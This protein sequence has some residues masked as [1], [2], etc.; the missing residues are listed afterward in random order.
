MDLISA[1][2]REMEVK[3]YNA[4]FINPNAVNE[5]LALYKDQGVYVLGAGIDKYY[6]NTSHPNLPAIRHRYNETR[7]ELTVKKKVEGN[8]VREEVNLLLAKS[9]LA[10]VEKMM[11]MLE[12]STALEISKLSHIFFLPETVISWYTVCDLQ[13]NILF[14]KDTGRKASFIEVEAREDIDWM[15]KLEHDADIVSRA[16]HKEVSKLTTAGLL[17]EREEKS[18]WELFGET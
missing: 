8:F 7:G 11:Q 2:F 10:E 4:N 5:F 3:Y 13:G 14:C 18:L 15:T 16:I 17:L 6:T 12:Y 9:S 1:N